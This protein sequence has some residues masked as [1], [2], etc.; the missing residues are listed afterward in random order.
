ML[1]VVCLVALARVSGGLSVAPSSQ[2]RAS[3]TWL[4]GVDVSTFGKVALRGDAGVVAETDVA[5]AEVM[6]S[7][8]A[9]L[10]L[11]TTATAG[12]AGRLASAALAARASPLAPWVG[13]WRGGG[14]ATDSA[15]LDE[16]DRGCKS[17]L[18]TGSDNDS[19][20]YRKFGMSCHPVVDR[21]A[22]RLAALTG[23]GVAEAR[24][25][26]LRRGAAFRACQDGLAAQISSP[27]ARAGLSLNE[28]R[29][30]EAA[31]FFS[32]AA[33]R[34]TWLDGRCAVVP[35]HDAL[36]HAGAEGENTKL[37]LDGDR[38]LLVAA[39]ALKRGDAL[40]RDYL[41]APSL[42][43]KDAQPTLKLLLEHGQRS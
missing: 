4:E 20:I 19:E 32:R 16:R 29:G 24:D 2:L 7:V 14:W 37:V 38:V 23:C 22:L 8:A 13:A 6:A 33:A 30:V 39:R 25:A 43:P 40:T 15:D 35:L 34:A 26:L 12:W 28:R 21:A 36:D 41:A 9:D 27:A 11:S 1:R 31:S 5:A 18:A 10:V 42:A 3:T 17:L